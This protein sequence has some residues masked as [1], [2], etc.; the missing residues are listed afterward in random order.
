[1]GTF[2]SK[3]FAILSTAWGLFIFSNSLKTG[4]QSATASDSIVDNLMLKL[5][6][7]ID[8]DLLTLLI[9]KAAHLCEF[10]LLGL[11][12][13]LCFYYMQ[14]RFQY[15]IPTILLIGLIAGVLD[16]FLQTFVVGRSGEVGDIVIDFTG[17][18][19]GF[20]IVYFVSKSKRK[21]NYHSR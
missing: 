11:L 2:K 6:L 9:R 18:L 12:V 5:G 4:S 20:F 8:T 7:T 15:S 1:M 21:Y 13:S 19:I 10:L 16:E 14:K 17:V 3:L